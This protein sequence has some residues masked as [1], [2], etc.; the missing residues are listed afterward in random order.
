M[1]EALELPLAPIL[2]AGGRRAGSPSCTR[3][4]G[5]RVLPGAMLESARGNGTRRGAGARRRARLGLRRGRSSASASRRPPPGSR[6]AGSET[7]GVRTDPSGRTRLPDVFAA[8][9]ALGPFDPRFGD[10]A[11]TEHWDA[12]AWQGA[13]AARAMLG[14]YSGPTPA[15]PASGATSTGCGSST[16]ATSPAPMRSSWAKATSTEP[17]GRCIAATGARWRR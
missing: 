7:E 9:D 3:S 1:V 2:G 14:E 12:A 6:A 17:S 8:G 13:A 16:S 5:V 10:H 11:R 15:C 4:E